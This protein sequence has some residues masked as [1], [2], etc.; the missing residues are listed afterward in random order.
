MLCRVLD[1]G[2]SVD[3]RLLDEFEAELGR[4]RIDRIKGKNDSTNRI[5]RVRVNGSNDRDDDGSKIIN[6][7]TPTTN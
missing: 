5:E 3:T 1:Q 6:T 4:I 2:I 7:S